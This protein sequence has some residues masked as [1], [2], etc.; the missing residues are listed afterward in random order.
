MEVVLEMPFEQLV[1][2]VKQLTP[3]QKAQLKKELGN[4]ISPKKKEH[5]SLTELLL[6]GPVFS[7]KQIEAIKNTR[8]SINTWRI[9]D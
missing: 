1:S 9:K 3:S 5:S 6:L 2:I 7:E 8:K 4:T